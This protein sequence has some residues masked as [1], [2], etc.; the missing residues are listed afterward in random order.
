MSFWSI[1][2]DFPFFI[3][4]ILVFGFNAC[5]SS[6]KIVLDRVSQKAPVAFDQ[7]SF[8]EQSDM[9]TSDNSETLDRIKSA[10]GQARSLQLKRL[11]AFARKQ[12]LEDEVL[13]CEA[14]VAHL[15]ER[16]VSC[17]DDLHAPEGSSS[18]IEGLVTRIKIIQEQAESVDQ[19]V[20]HKV[21]QSLEA[22]C[23]SPRN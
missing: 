19:I 10:E 17:V 20:K 5:A 15:G 9:S 7:F 18:R 8:I 22:P 11:V 23:S 14:I 21:S 12:A 13:Q 1:I 16:A 4:V 6:F 3:F 2:K